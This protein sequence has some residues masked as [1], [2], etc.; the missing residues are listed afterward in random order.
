MRQKLIQISVLA[1]V[2]LAG[3]FAILKNE[4]SGYQSNLLEGICDL[5]TLCDGGQRTELAAGRPI[6]GFT[7]KHTEDISIEA[8]LWKAKRG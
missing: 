5:T 2:W 8:K 3:V 4:V 1:R 7:K 6:D